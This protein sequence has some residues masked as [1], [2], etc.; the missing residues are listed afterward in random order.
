MSKGGSKEISLI[1]VN[2]THLL[3]IIIYGVIKAHLSK[4]HLSSPQTSSE[5]QEQFIIHS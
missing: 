3:K 5:N 1:L 2:N 4:A